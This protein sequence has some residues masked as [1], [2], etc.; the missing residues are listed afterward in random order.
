MDYKLPL[1][2]ILIGA[3]VFVGFSAF[4]VSARAWPILSD[5]GLNSLYD[6]VW[7][8]FTDFLN[9]NYAF[10]SAGQ[11][12]YDVCEGQYFAAMYSHYYGNFIGAVNYQNVQCPSGP[13]CAI[14]QDS[15]ANWGELIAEL[16]THAGTTYSC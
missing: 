5:S 12:H 15:A 7:Q 9:Q 1:Q 8:G 6:Q 13:Y 3:T 4:S 10:C 14:A 16:G 2:K 11:W